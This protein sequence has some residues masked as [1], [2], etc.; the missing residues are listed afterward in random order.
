MRE[1]LTQ[2]VRRLFVVSIVALLITAGCS[3]SETEVAEPTET[4]SPTPAK[5]PTDDAA[6]PQD[7]PS[8]PAPDPTPM[9]QVQLLFPRD[10][11]SFEDFLAMFP[12]DRVIY[13]DGADDP[14]EVVAGT[15]M[16]W[17][18]GPTPEEL[19]R[20]FVAPVT[21]DWSQC[22]DSVVTPEFIGET[23]VVTMCGNLGSAGI[24]QDARA[25]ESFRQTM[26]AAGVSDAVLLAEDGTW[27][28]G[29]MGDDPLSCLSDEQRQALGSGTPCPFGP[30]AQAGAIT[31]VNEAVN[32][33]T[34]P[35]LDADIETMIPLGDEVTFFVPFSNVRN[36]GFTWFAVRPA[37][38]MRCV[39]VASDF[40]ATLVPTE[41][42]P[43]AGIAYE[44][45]V[46]G[47]WRITPDDNDLNAT[48]WLLDGAFYTAL[49]ISV[50]SGTNIQDYI[51][52]QEGV[53][54]EF[55]YDL[56]EVWYEEVEL[57]GADRAIRPVVIADREGDVI[58]DQLFIEV[59]GY[60]ITVS[61]DIYIEDYD[62]VPVDEMTAFVDS[63]LV[64]RD[65]FLTGQ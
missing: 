63:V 41:D 23:M 54:D 20:G 6:D 53:F 35:S 4:A 31:G 29:V 52:H 1:S 32:A 9:T 64:D 2:P 15:L 61:S 37:G 19:D 49:S 40:I 65:A 7:G 56:P 43:P 10:P 39:W 18:N 58:F 25:V 62:N 5:Q 42:Q 50:E 27:C 38:W 11:E 21:F 28:Y 12:V 30:D 60:T 16:A 13:L 48:T 14:R 55:D 26:A 24:G 45:P 51:A 57:D 47:T 3:V 34:A 22:Y 46:T 17:A 59:D 8:D 33:R 36:G 44:L